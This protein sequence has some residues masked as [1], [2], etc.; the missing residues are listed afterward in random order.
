VSR[1]DRCDETCTTDCGHCKGWG[2]PREL[3]GATTEGASWVYPANAGE[4][5]ARWNAASLE[6]REQRVQG[7]VAASQQMGT[8][9]YGRHEERLRELQEQVMRL[10]AQLDE[11]RVLVGFDAAHPG[12]VH[13]ELDMDRPGYRV[14]QHP[15][16]SLD[17]AAGIHDA[18]IDEDLPT[19]AGA[20]L[21]IT[22]TEGDDHA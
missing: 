21:K 11:R 13:F 4:F 7:M 9:V 8:C 2:V 19:T 3:A 12:F 16:C 6:E 20:V 10:T 18:H 15:T 5:A 22:Y 1:Y 14:V 17:E